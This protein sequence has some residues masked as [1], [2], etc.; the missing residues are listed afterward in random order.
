MMFL[1]FNQ[2][3]IAARHDVNYGCG[4]KVATMNGED[5]T[6]MVRQ[7]YSWEQTLSVIDT[8]NYCGA[9][10]LAFSRHWSCKLLVASEMM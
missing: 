2:D 5:G 10:L 8:L 4:K 6:T 1:L 7:L 3:C 9:R